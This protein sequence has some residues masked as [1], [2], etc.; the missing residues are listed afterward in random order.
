MS[1]TTDTGKSL[2]LALAAANMK[3]KDLAEKAGISEN[4]VSRLAV[5]KAL[6]QGEMLDRI[7]SAFGMKASE[8]LALGED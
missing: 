4:Y 2:R 1:T 5:G 6:I 7:A 3:N 8:F